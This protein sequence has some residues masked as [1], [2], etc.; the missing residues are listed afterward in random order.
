MESVLRNGGI[1]F[2]IRNSYAKIMPHGFANGLKGK[3]IRI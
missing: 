1:L 3:V 2:Y